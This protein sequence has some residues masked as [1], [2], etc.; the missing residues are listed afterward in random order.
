MNIKNKVKELRRS[1]I[2][3]IA[4][5][6]V[7]K[8]GDHYPNV[9]PWSLGRV[10]INYG[11]IKDTW[12]E[13]G[14]R[15]YGDEVRG[16]FFEKGKFPSWKDSEVILPASS[17]SRLIKVQMSDIKVFKGSISGFIKSITYNIRKYDSI[18]SVPRIASS[19][20]RALS[21]EYGIDNI[22]KSEV[23]KAMELQLAEKEREERRRL[24]WKNEP[25]PDKFQFSQPEVKQYP[26]DKVFNWVGEQSSL[27]EWK[28]YFKQN[29]VQQKVS[30]S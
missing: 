17:D 18:T 13:V 27:E 3:K 29:Y 14:G 24:N 10:M 16:G 11:P 23:K 9:V 12:Y 30:T 5:Y 1:L 6:M 19:F 15:H 20:L 26:D 4:R 28:E 7:N 8:L 2:K 21:G 25:A 22:A